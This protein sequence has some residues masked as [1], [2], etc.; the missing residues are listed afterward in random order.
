MR[1]LH[2]QPTQVI[3][4]E[5]LPLLDEMLARLRQSDRDALV[6]RFFENKTL[7]EVGAALGL[8]ERAAQKRVARSL[9]KLRL[10]FLKRGVALSTTAI[11]GA[12]SAHS[13]QAA[14]AGLKV[15]A[16][17][18]AKGNAA[19]VG[20]LTLAQDGLKWM[21]WIKVRGVLGVIVPV[22]C[23]T[24]A[25]ARLSADSTLIAFS[26]FGAVKRF[27]QSLA[28][29]V[30]GSTVNKNRKLLGFRGRAESFQPNVSGRLRTIEIAIQSAGPGRINVSLARDDNGL[31]GDILE[32]FSN[33]FPPEFPSSIMISSVST[34]DD[35]SSVLPPEIPLP[36]STLVLKSRTTPTLLAGVN[37][38]LCIEPSDGA[39]YCVWFQTVEPVN[40]PMAFDSAP[41]S[42]TSVQAQPMTPKNTGRGHGAF[43]IKLSPTGRTTTSPAN[44]PRD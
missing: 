32:R 3:W 43:S 33:I 1:S 29:S 6:L 22:V 36:Y 25:V 37:Y 31:P 12:V 7:P 8:Q 41:G 40:N 17:A 18:A 16:V 14:P 2:E 21:T 10:M 5:M 35:L 38:W 24:L 4:E 13:V 44:K 19:T 39:T 28:W 34:L 20:A 27:D 42:W 23:V 15:S 11:S 26:S 9:E 30:S